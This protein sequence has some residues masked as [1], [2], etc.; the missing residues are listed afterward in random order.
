MKIMGDCIKVKLN[1]RGII[2]NETFKTK[3]EVDEW[4]KKIVKE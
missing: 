2:Y 4:F 1:Y 3:E